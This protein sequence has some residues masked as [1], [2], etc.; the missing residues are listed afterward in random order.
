MQ[1]LVIAPN[2]SSLTPLS[3]FARLFLALA[4]SKQERPQAVAEGAEDLL[5]V[6]AGAR[7]SR[8]ILRQRPESAAGGVHPLSVLLA[9]QARHLEWTAASLTSHGLLVGEFSSSML[10]GATAVYRPYR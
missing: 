4:G 10:V 7:L 5:A 8:E 6:H 2:I 9:D 3:V 1:S